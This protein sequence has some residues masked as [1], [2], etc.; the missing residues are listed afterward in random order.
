[1]TRSGMGLDA[2]VH[3]R[4][5]VAWLVTLVV[6][7]PP[8]SYKVEH[9]ILVEFVPVCQCDLDDAIRGFRVVAVYVKYRHLRYLRRVGR[10]DRGAAQLR[11]CRKADL[12]VDDE[13]DRAARAIADQAGELERFHYDALP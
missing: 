7:E 6:A 13:M 2:S 10:V 11:R 1:M 9:N 4:L 5:R 3:H 12:I 8:K